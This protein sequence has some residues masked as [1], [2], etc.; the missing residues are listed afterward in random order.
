MHILLIHQAF[1]SLDEAGG[2]RHA[3]LARYL[4]D[5][6]HQVTII[7]SPVSY[8]TGRKKNSSDQQREQVH[9]PGITIHNAR[10]YSKYNKSFFHR[11]LSFFSFMFSSF[12]IG[13][14]VKKPDVVWG[15]TP[16]IFQAFTAWLVARLKRARFLLEVRDLWPGFAIALGVIKNPLIKWLSLGLEKFL[17]RHADRIIVNSPGFIEHVR[18]LGGK[19]VYLIPNGADPAMFISVD[20]GKSFRRANHLE[21]KFVITYAGAHGISNDLDTVLFAAE[22]LKDLHSIKI[23]LV[24]DGKEKSA[25]MRT[26]TGLNLSNVQFLDPLP[27]NKISDLLAASD[28]CIAILKPIELYKT[29]YPNKV[30]DYMAAGKP[31]ICA[32]DGEIRKVVETAHAGIFVEP[33]NPVQLANAIRKLVNEPQLVKVMGQS[34]KEYL[35]KNFQREKSSQKFEAI[36]AGMAAV[37]D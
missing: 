37:N 1:T 4:A 27:K 14:K 8:L 3:E 10:T 34:G 19:K 20:S 9:N 26:A 5:H 24:G 17:Y 13:L 30:F 6:G 22:K 23:L 31:V 18:S 12:F 28:A 15:T 16:P 35:E 32:I 36:I 33:G 29:T 21:D 11:I 7:A 25:L 2:T